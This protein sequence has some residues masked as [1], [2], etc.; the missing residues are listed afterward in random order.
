MEVLY[1]PVLT[2]A[3]MYTQPLITECM[4]TLQNE[5]KLFQQNLQES[6]ER[7]G[8]ICHTNAALQQQVQ[9]SLTG[10]S[11]RRRLR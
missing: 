8:V 11:R 1:L 6:Q 5:Q 9:H 3:S 10:L 4:V 7:E 2:S